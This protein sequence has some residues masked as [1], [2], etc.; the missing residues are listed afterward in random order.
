MERMKPAFLGGLV[1]TFVVG[2][3]LLMNGA[4][5]RFPRL[6][7]GRSLASII[8]LPDNIFAGWVLFVV[9]GIFGFS[10]LFA[11]LAPR[12]PVKTHLVKGLL[13]GAACWLVM[14][15]VFEP[16]SG[17]GWFAFDRGL[18][19]TALCLILNLVYGV[20]LSLTYRWLMGTEPAARTVKA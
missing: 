13:F 14:M 7:I 4:M 20:I 2:S 17:Q 5:H 12:I 16:L 6:W 1:A 11:I 8:G 18:M 9:L 10:A 15:V 19:V 3:M